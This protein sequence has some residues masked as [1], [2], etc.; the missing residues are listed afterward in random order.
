MW[1]RLRARRS[2]AGQLARA[3]FFFAPSC[4]IVA[5]ASDRELHPAVPLSGAAD[6]TLSAARLFL[7]RQ[8]WVWPVLAAA[9]LL[10]IGLWVR[11]SVEKSQKADLSE[12][13]TGIL[14]ADVEAL[15]MW[16]KAQRSNVT[17]AADAFLV[18]G[19]ARELVALGSREGTSVA[20]LV[21]APAQNEL[22]QALK[23]WIE[24][25]GY[26]GFFV[27][28]QSRKIVASSY[29]DLIGK[30]SLEEY[31]PFLK[32]ALEG[33]TT[34]SR[35]FP[36][37]ILV[38]DETGRLR[39]GVQTMF[40]VA[41]LRDAGGVAAGALALRIR[42]ELDFTRILQVARK[43]NSGE[44]YAIDRRGLLL[45]ESRFDEDLKRLGLLPDDDAARSILT[46]VVKDPQVDMMSGGRPRGRRGDL[47]LT[48]AATA[49]VA[50]GS[51]VDVEGYR[52]YRGVLSLG[53][54][55][56]LEE[57]EIGV[58]TEVDRA[59]AYRALHII[60]TTFW[61]LFTLLSASAVAIFVF[62]LVSSR[63]KQSA[64]QASLLARRLGQYTLDEM[65]GAG[66]MGVVYRA[67][68]AMLRRPTAVKL[69][70]SSKTTDTALQ[71][72]ER[73]VQI[74]SRLN[75]PNTICIY[76]YGRTPDGVFYYAMEYLDGIDLESLV[77]RFGPQPEGRVIDILKQVCGSL[78]EAHGLGLIHR[79]IKPANI[80]LNHRGGLVDF[81]KVLDFGLVKAVDPGKEAALTAANCIT[82]T[83]LYMSPEAIERVDEVGPWSDLYAVG[84]VGYFLLTGQPVFQGQNMLDL[85]KQQAEAPPVPPSQRLGKPVSPDLERLLL[86]CL[87]KRAE[88]RPAT[89]EELIA[90]LSTCA[91]S[92][93]WTRDDARKWWVEFD[94][95]GVSGVS[96]ANTGSV[97]AEATV[98]SPLT[99]IVGTSK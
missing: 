66:G 73:E 97:A 13:L 64:R 57:Y 90:R 38:P 16:M 19:L 70:N 6:V 47:P 99:Q 39:A 34:V 23:P 60:R 65:I 11:H 37:V 68:H 75:H 96:I 32:T 52:D 79:D 80:V 89:A 88:E 49:V 55:R 5:M 51:G 78:A 44:T 41:P 29:D 63:W 30:Q 72:F 84:A 24:A 36:S 56:W 76:D 35:P 59:E 2:L 3:L 93:S 40:T 91:V 42:P 33:R 26:A 45:S 8:L 82:G 58:I 12:D 53:A 28:D 94:R 25:H 71:R 14:N 15:E 9:L 61:G 95:T 7:Q 10:V 74:T 86:Q 18:N 87:A 67:H 92:T 83:P 50:G 17:A 1:E 21:Q 46:V 27:A 48:R 43:G 85:L 4:T 77:E 81:V 62:S 20:E 69:L 22:R 98:A 54:W 31:E